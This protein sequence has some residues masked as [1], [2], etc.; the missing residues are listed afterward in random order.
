MAGMCG[1]INNLLH[2][3]LSQFLSHNVFTICNKSS[4]VLMKTNLLNRNVN[5]SLADNNQIQVNTDHNQI[6]SKPE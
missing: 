5:F 1:I 2:K 4:L 6:K 3:Q